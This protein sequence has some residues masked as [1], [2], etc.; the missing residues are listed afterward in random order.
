MAREPAIEGYREIAKVLSEVWGV[1]VSEDAA[2]RAATRKE[3]PLP[4]DG[5]A[6]RVWTTRSAI[7]KWVTDERQR[8]RRLPVASGNQLGLFELDET[9]QK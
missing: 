8:R 6:G 4:T 9:G 5:Y 7:E 1:T 3:S 2:Y